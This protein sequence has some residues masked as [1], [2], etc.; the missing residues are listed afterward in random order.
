MHD[1]SML[2]DCCSTRM[3]VCSQLL[4][5]EI[6]AV[7]GRMVSS[8]LLTEVLHGISDMYDDALSGAQSSK[9]MRAVSK[10][11]FDVTEPHSTNGPF[12]SPLS[13]T[14][15]DRSRSCNIVH[16]LNLK[17]TQ[18]YTPPKKEKFQKRFGCRTT[19]EIPSHE[20]PRPQPNPIQQSQK[21]NRPESGFATS[22]TL[23]NKA[24]SETRVGFR[25][26]WL[27]RQSYLI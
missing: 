23:G 3:S 22:K 21:S 5:A 25:V 15:H 8:S 11:H 13:C 19:L 2:L 4:G 14:P 12:P 10:H 16:L 26:L 27:M 9:S 24:N 6:S 1:G 7:L 17:P 20:S 18:S